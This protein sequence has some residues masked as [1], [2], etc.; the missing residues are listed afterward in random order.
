MTAKRPGKA[1]ASYSR[2]SKTGDVT[3]QV[4]EKLLQRLPAS[5]GRITALREVHE[6]LA[7]AT[8]LYREHGDEGRVGVYRAVSDV[9]EYFASQGVPRA[10]LEPL[11]AVAV[12][13]VDADDGTQSPIFKPDRKRGGG[14]PRKR[15]DVLVFEGYVAVVVDCCVRHC[16]TQGFRPYVDRGARL[17]ASMINKSDWY[18]RVT[19]TQ[20]REIRERV[21]QSASSSPDRILLDQSMSSE[22]AQDR[23]LEWAKLLLKHDWVSSQPSKDSA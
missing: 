15:S 23:P 6:K 18:V 4:S 21:V 5:K 14:K 8:V 22:V 11:S 13:I 7:A 9:I 12:A 10:V 1:S 3:V 17:A 19:A 16:K 2:D 20:L